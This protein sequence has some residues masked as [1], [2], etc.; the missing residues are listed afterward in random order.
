MKM[1]NPL[2]IT[3]LMIAIFLS[4]CGE[5]D[6]SNDETPQVTNQTPNNADADRTNGEDKGEDQAMAAPGAFLT[7]F[8]ES[9]KFFTIMDS[10]VAGNSPHG[11]SL[12][13][14]STNIR[15]LIDKEQFTVPEGT[16][17]IKAFDNEGDDAIEGYAIMIKKESGYDPENNDWYYEMRNPDGTLMESPE[18]GANPMCIG[19]H[20]VAKSTDYLAGTELGQ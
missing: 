20:A 15:E 10:F 3:G 11:R 16:V 12:I 13:Y 5:S 19:C 8:E 2:F 1:T 9:D 6:S 17:S 4:S 18:P 14:Y 7:D